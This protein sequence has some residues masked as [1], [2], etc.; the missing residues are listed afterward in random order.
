MALP[1]TEA[2]REK[3]AF[4]DAL[5]RPTRERMEM[6]FRLALICALTTLVTDTTVRRSRR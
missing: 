2:S 5:L 1:A 4:L 6:A 3:R